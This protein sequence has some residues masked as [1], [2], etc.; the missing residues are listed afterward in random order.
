M[1]QTGR[2]KSYVLSATWF[3]WPVVLAASSLHFH[4]VWHISLLLVGLW[5]LPGAETGLTDHFLVDCLWLSLPASISLW[6]GSS[7]PTN[8]NGYFCCI[9]L[10]VLKY[11]AWLEDFAG[12][13][14][15]KANVPD[16]LL[17]RELGGSVTFPT[18]WLTRL[19]APLSKVQAGVKYCI[20]FQ[21]I[22]HKN[23]QVRAFRVWP[24][25]RQRGCQLWASKKKRK[26]V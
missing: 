24:W 4:L 7:W 22:G 20:Y 25:P 23:F 13:R 3:E 2:R 26:K 10:C 8:G 16:S 11:E 12:K 1:T 14:A 5:L 19:P 18:K 21:S 6:S 17:N 9:L 15:H